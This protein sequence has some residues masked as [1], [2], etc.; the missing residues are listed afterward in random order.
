MRRVAVFI[1]WQNCYHLARE[2]FHQE[3][4]PSR[5]GNVRPRA[6]AEML[7]GKG[8]AGDR[9]THLAI[10]RGEPSPRK[11]PQTHAAYMRQRQSWVDDCPPDVLRVRTRAVRYPPGRPLSEAVEKGIDVQMAIDAMVMGLQDAYDLAILATADTDL[12]PVVEG[13]V[14]LKEATGKPDVAVIGWAGTSRHLEAGV[15]VRWIG[16]KDYETVRNREDF[17]LSP[18]DRRSP[19][20]R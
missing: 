7:V 13:L 15:P 6:F 5:Y 14:A 18:A 11:D 8:N 9:L 3:D 20:I 1:D 10:Y 19:R 2:A 16:K 12:L 17:N 4:E